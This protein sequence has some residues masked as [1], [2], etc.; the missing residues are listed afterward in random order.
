MRWQVPGITCKYYGEPSSGRQAMA[1]AMG[2]E[3]I[4]SPDH[5]QRANKD[6][7]ETIKGVHA[8]QDCDVWQW[9]EPRCPPWPGVD[10]LSTR[11]STRVA[12]IAATLGRWMDTGVKCVFCVQGER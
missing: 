7:S 8:V 5:T 6:L 12:G 4:K 10:R 9:P 3:L 11:A 2:D 1:K